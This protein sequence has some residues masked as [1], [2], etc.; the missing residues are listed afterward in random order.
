MDIS[1][2][3]SDGTKLINL[4]EVLQNRRC[5]GKVYKNNPSQIQML[6]NVQLALDAM[7]DDGVKLVNIGKCPKNNDEIW[8]ELDLP[9]TYKQ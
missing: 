2:D 4:V 8:K 3:F 9:L 7:R 1:K 6:A 5:T